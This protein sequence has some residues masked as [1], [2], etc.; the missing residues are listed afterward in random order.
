MANTTDVGATRPIST[1]TSTMASAEAIAG[2]S[3]V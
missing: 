1:M 2:S 3:T